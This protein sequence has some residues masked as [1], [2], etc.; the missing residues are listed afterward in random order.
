MQ[1]PGSEV[2]NKQR[3]TDL[4]SSSDTGWRFDWGQVIK[5]SQTL[6]K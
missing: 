3:R 2:T 6:A 1:G 5:S 4:R